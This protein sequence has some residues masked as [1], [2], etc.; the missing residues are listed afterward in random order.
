AGHGITVTAAN[1]VIHADRWWNPAVENQ[2]TDR[3]HR[4]G[5]TKTVYVYRIMVENTLEE[6]IEKLLQ[7]KQAIADTIIDSARQTTQQWTREELLE[8]LRPLSDD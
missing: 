5:Q 2:A 8:I 4:I 6:R 7:R 1:H 3:V